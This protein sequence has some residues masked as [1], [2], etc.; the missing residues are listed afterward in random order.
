MTCGMPLEGAH[1]KDIGLETPEGFV[2]VHDVKDGNI[3]SGEDIFEGGVQFFLS[4]VA[5][6]DRN[7]A[8]RLTRKNMKRLEYWKT[9][10]FSMLEGTEATDEEFAAAMVYNTSSST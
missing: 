1:E 7:L 6:G 5:S 8:E 3:K 2:C 9:H 4:S 10:P